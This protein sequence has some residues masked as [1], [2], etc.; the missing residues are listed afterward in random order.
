[1]PPLQRINLYVQYR[2]LSR[3][4]LSLRR[5][6]E[7]KHN[8][9]PAE[10]ALLGLIRKLPEYSERKLETL[11]LKKLLGLRD[12]SLS[13]KA[14]VEKYIR[15]KRTHPH[16]HTL[17][18]PLLREVL[19]NTGLTLQQVNG[20]ID[21][22]STAS[23]K[24]NTPSRRAVN[25]R[26]L[27]ARNQIL[28]DRINSS[29]AFE[30]IN[31]SGAL[32]VEKIEGFLKQILRSSQSETA[33][34]RSLS[35]FINRELKTEGNN[36]AARVLSK[37]IATLLLNELRIQLARTGK[38]VNRENI[39]AAIKQLNKLL[40]RSRPKEAVAEKPIEKKLVSIA[41]RKAREHKTSYRIYTDAK[42]EVVRIELSGRLKALLETTRRAINPKPKETLSLVAR[43]AVQAIRQN[44][45]SAP[46]VLNFVAEVIS[47]NFGTS[48][49]V[50]AVEVSRTSI[51]RITEM[52]LGTI[53]SNLV[54]PSNSHAGV[55]ANHLVPRERR[56]II[57]DLLGEYQKQ[58]LPV[59]VKEAVAAKD[60]AAKREIEGL[61]R[62]YAKTTEG[63][64]YILA[65]FARGKNSK[66]VKVISSIKAGRE[67]IQRVVQQL[68]SA[69]APAAKKGTKTT[70]ASVVSSIV[71]NNPDKFPAK[72]MTTETA[73][74]LL[75]LAVRTHRAIQ[76]TN[77]RKGKSA[78]RAN[79]KTNYFAKSP[80]TQRTQPTRAIS[81]KRLAKVAQTVRNFSKA[82]QATDLALPTALKERLKDN[83]A[84]LG[85][86]APLAPTSAAPKEGAFAPPKAAN[87]DKMIESMLKGIESEMAA[88]KSQ[89]AAGVKAIT[90]SNPIVENTAASF[91][92]VD[93]Y[94]E[95]RRLVGEAK[96]EEALAKVKEIIIRLEEKGHNV[97]EIV[98]ALSGNS[99]TARVLLYNMVLTMSIENT[100]NNENQP[101]LA[102]A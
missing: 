99:R 81:G 50:R 15:L 37:L 87:N 17:P 76:V 67:A 5:T 53:V 68:S 10:T 100:L 48:Q 27:T 34:L 90:G 21:K 19:R 1:M 30:S 41:A 69:P 25:Q 71:K 55:S 35:R 24:T 96:Y 8:R 31:I 22:K 95:L 20:A 93:F 84:A 39:K 18:L 40:S 94:N 86:Q 9:T 89:A 59:L 98:K 66:P 56:G 83:L 63:Q 91:S 51:P 80:Y 43:E 102:S 77:K 65:A 42:G 23:T 3:N 14:S 97:H 26:N 38:E 79:R 88:Q 72:G 54:S 29:V 61:V 12:T 82:A 92:M 33:A 45:K 57:K 32:S 73:K 62:E 85:V 46:K 74:D 60:P 28:A 36:R 70:V 64:E 58:A 49:N 75:E 16:N 2:Q 52:V 44:P 4:L 7:L 101:Q 78:K 6:L 13:L 11:S 47:Q